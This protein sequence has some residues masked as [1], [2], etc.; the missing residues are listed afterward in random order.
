MAALAGSDF[1][2]SGLTVGRMGESC[3]RVTSPE[4]RV[5]SSTPILVNWTTFGTLKSR[6]KGMSDEGALSLLE[7]R[8]HS[9]RSRP[10]TD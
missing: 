4:T 2:A 8:R 5:F 3:S 9:A 10:K 7:R 1:C 6:E